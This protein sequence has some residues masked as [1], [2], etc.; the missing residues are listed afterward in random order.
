MFKKTTSP[1]I[2]SFWQPMTA[3]NVIVNNKLETFT[4]EC[5]K[6]EVVDDYRFSIY[7][8]KERRKQTRVYVELNDLE[9]ARKLIKKVQSAGYIALRNWVE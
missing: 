6:E 2:K 9:E 8:W 3:N 4:I 5:F 1:I 7:H